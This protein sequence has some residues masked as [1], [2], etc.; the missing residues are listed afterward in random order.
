MNTVAEIMHDWHWTA[1]V[2]LSTAE[3]SRM[4]DIVF[5]MQR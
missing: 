1:E 3:G 2:E 4:H 5:D